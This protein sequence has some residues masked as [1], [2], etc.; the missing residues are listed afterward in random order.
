MSPP[1]GLNA[2]ADRIA[3]RLKTVEDSIGGPAVPA[4]GR[5]PVD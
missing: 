4:T 2:P 3:G 1:C 5:S